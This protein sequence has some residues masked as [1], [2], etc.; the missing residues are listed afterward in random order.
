MQR[1]Y[2]AYNT[3]TGYKSVVIDKRPAIL[4]IY[5]TLDRIAMFLVQNR[6]TLRNAGHALGNSSDLW[7]LSLSFEALGT[8]CCHGYHRV[9]DSHHTDHFSFHSAIKEPITDSRM[10]I[11]TQ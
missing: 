5:M 1:T 2:W 6:L 11:D 8:L 4:N 9:T 7:K 3:K 10:T